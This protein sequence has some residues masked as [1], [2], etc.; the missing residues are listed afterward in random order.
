MNRFDLAKKE[1]MAEQVTGRMAV[2][3]AIAQSLVV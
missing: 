3:V 2:A 1:P